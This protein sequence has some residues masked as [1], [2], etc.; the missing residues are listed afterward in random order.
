MSVTCEL[1]EWCGWQVPVLWIKEKQ[2]RGSIQK[3]QL[4]WQG[5]CWAQPSQYLLEHSLQSHAPEP[6][7]VCR[8]ELQSSCWQ[9]RT[10]ACADCSVTRA[11]AKHCHGN[12]ACKTPRV[13]QNPGALERLLLEHCAAGFAGRNRSLFGLMGKRLV[14]GSRSFWR[15]GGGVEGLGV[16]ILL[17][18]QCLSWLSLSLSFLRNLT[19]QS[20]QHHSDNQTQGWH[21]SQ[22]SNPC[23]EWHQA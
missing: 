2:H 3:R 10:T 6:S 1:G 4:G 9:G 14:R 19:W 20:R 16:L 8:P 12:Q 7:D 22:L 17:V 18:T 21:L 13:L 11:F 23:E 5:P 15:L